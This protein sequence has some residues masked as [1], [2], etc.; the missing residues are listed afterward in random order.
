MWMAVR[1]VEDFSRCAGRLQPCVVWEKQVQPAL[2]IAL[3]C[4]F[5]PV[6]RCPLN[7][8]ASWGS[9]WGHSPM[10]ELNT[11]GSWLRT[12]LATGV[13]S[14]DKGKE[15]LVLILF[16]CKGCVKTRAGLWE[17]LW[18]GGKRKKHISVPCVSG[19]TLAS[20]PQSQYWSPRS[21]D[22]SLEHLNFLPFSQYPI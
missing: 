9:L 12:L 2:L 6:S 10:A 20:L 4:R 17:C 18:E 1:C 3:S 7:S 19:D 21:L 22:S 15:S 14:G 11:E 8:E 5:I 13:T 16:F